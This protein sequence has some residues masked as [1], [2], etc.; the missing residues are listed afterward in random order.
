MKS[1]R[2]TWFSE[3]T[4]EEQQIGIARCRE[5]SGKAETKLVGYSTGLGNASLA[6]NASLSMSA[7]HAAESTQ[8]NRVMH[9]AALVNGTEW[10]TK[11]TLKGT[12]SKS[13]QS[14]QAIG[15]EN[16][17]ANGMRITSVPKISE[18]VQRISKPINQSA[19]STLTAVLPPHHSFTIEELKLLKGLDR[20]T[21]KVTTPIKVNMLEFLTKE[22]PNHPFVEY[23]LD[24]LKKGFRYGFTGR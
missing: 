12:R 16:N 2:N 13:S 23:I 19:E 5:L 20:S 24:G 7:S 1:I 4:A 11:A 17:L 18:G 8:R 9:A 6:G 14:Q 15:H 21:F 3:G 22:H 10:V